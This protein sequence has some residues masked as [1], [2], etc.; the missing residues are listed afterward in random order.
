[1][2]PLLWGTKSRWIQRQKVKWWLPGAKGGEYGDG[3]L[4]GTDF[5]FLKMRSVVETDW[6]NNVNILDTIELKHLKMMKMVDFT[7]HVFH[8]N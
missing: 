7:S 4:I 3:C 1:M 6:A 8:H 2:I 5:Q